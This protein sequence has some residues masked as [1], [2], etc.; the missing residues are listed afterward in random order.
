MVLAAQRAI[1]Q[2]GFKPG[3]FTPQGDKLKIE[4]LVPVT[5]DF[6]SV[7]EDDV[8]SL[9]RRAVDTKGRV[10]DVVPPIKRGPGRPRK[11]V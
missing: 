2:A 8:H 5:F 4:V 3:A 6:G 1:K 9:V 10:P 7:V 11:V